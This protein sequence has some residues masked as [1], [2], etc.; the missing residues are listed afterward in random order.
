MDIPF[1]EVDWNRKLR[2]NKEYK[3][4]FFNI[5][6]RKGGHALVTNIGVFRNCSLEQRDMSYAVLDSS[7]AERGRIWYDIKSGG[8]LHTERCV[9][10]G[11][12]SCKDERGS[13]KYYILVVGL[14]NVDGE[15]TRVGAGWIQSDYVARQRLSVRVV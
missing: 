1:G 13:R 12:D 14:T 11:R 7:R 8:D 5:F 10:V 2:F 6:K 15:Y 3:H 4:I 9:V